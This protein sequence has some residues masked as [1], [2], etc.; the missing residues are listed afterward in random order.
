[1]ILNDYVVQDSI[2]V[3]EQT[4]YASLPK[5]KRNLFDMFDHMMMK[6]AENNA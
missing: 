5:I 1:M 2:D 3:E 6:A 4:G